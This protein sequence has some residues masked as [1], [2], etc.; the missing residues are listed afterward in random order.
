MPDA[1]C[2]AP[3]SSRGY[4]ICQIAGWGSFAIYVL[5]SYLWAVGPARR[6]T[7]AASILFFNVVV[8]PLVMH[9]VRSGMYSRGWIQLPLRRLVARLIPVVPALA[10]FLTALVDV[11]ALVLNGGHGLSWPS[12]A[13]VFFGFCWAFAGW[14]L[15]YFT[16]HARRRHDALRLELAVTS[17]DA[18][19]QSL[20]AQLN[21]HF[22]FNCLNSLR[23]LIVED[24]ARAAS[25]VTG[26]AE[27][28]RYSLAS[29]RMDTV[30][31]AEELDVIDEYVDLERI[32]FE[33]RLRVERDVERSAL[34]ARI[35]PMLVQTLVENAVKHG[36]S[37]LPQGGVVRLEARTSGGR[38]EIRVTNTG[39]LKTSA[40]AT[41]Y[42]LRNAAERLRLLYGD[43]AS[44]TL[45]DND[46]TTVAALSLPLE[47]P[48][49]RATR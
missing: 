30:R 36:I 38:L 44:L 2:R 40:D 39:R 16:V 11:S 25:M 29:D 15:I 48:N 23:S 20:R 49:E 21:P 41:G 18:Q 35:P 3:R 13:G 34:D 26:L 33:E 14:F 17:R 12:L 43:T 42:G 28:L 45:R 6:L 24:P 37:E 7:D 10:G 27:I 5:A 9:M 22:L 4:W 32:R 19:L 46:G 8:C 47:P 31:F 1:R